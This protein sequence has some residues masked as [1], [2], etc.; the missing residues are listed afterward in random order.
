VSSPEAFAQFTS[1][2]P[3]DWPKRSFEVVLHAEVH[4]AVPGK[5]RVV[6]WHVW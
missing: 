6:A 4:G 2:A 1:V 3:A 5:P